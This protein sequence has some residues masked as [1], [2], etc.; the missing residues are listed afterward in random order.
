MFICVS[1]WLHFRV[2]ELKS[3]RMSKYGFQ[4]DREIAMRM[5]QE[6]LGNK[7]NIAKSQVADWTESMVF[8]TLRYSYLSIK[9]YL[10]KR[11]VAMIN[12]RGKAL[13]VPI[14]LPNLTS[15]LEMLERNC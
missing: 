15:L 8:I 13:G 5:L 4:P 3:N 1:W 9:E 14:M 6:H 12:A 2:K 7:N 11:Q 10:V